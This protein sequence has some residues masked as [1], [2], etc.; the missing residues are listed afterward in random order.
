MPDGGGSPRN[1]G[2]RHADGLDDANWA[3]LREARPPMILAG[4]VARCASVDAED[5]TNDL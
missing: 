2:D 1:P 5:R 3:I 4:W